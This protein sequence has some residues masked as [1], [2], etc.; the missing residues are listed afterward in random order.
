VE[1]RHFVGEWTGKMCQAVEE[2]AVDGGS[3]D[4]LVSVRK[5]LIFREL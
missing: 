5:P 2:V 1:K 4:E 3:S